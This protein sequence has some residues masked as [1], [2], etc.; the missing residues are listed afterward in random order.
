MKIIFKI[1]TKNEKLKTCSQMYFFQFHVK[2]MKF[3]LQNRIILWVPL[4]DNLDN[5][6]THLTKPR[7]QEEVGFKQYWYYSYIH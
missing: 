7:F 2:L 6:P 1:T 5:Q 4:I 3:R